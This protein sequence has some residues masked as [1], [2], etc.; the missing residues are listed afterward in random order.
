MKRGLTVGHLIEVLERIEE[1]Y[2][3]VVDSNGKPITSVSDDGSK[4]TIQFLDVK[5]GPEYETRT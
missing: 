3:P 1:K 5:A 4:I 2:L